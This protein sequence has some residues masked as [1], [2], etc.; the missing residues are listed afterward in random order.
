MA[1]VWKHKNKEFIAAEQKAFEDKVAQ[2]V[3]KRLNEV[4]QASEETEVLEE[5]EA[6][7][8]TDETDE[9]VEA[10][11]NLQVE[12]AAVINNNESSSEGDSLRERFAKTF[13]E[14]VKISY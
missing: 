5:A 11:D 6:S 12:E 7:E 2:E 13:K 10:L 4:S 1:K 8:E 14:S 3:E 9:V